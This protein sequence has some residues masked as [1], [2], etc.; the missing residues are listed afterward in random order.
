MSKAYVVGS[1]VGSGAAFVAAKLWHG[2]CVVAA[3]A[4]DAGQ[5]FMDGGEETWGQQTAKDEAKRIATAAAREAAVEAR[6]AAK[7]AAQLE[8]PQATPMAVA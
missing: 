4:G 1:K 7:K 5:G 3:A 6:I 2:T 8:T